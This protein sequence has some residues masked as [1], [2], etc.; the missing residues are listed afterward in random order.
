MATHYKYSELIKVN[1]ILN[2]KLMTNAIRQKN[3]IKG[4]KKHHE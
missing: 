2:D 1:N 4:N 3:A